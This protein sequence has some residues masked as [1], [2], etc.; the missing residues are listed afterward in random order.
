M[1]KNANQPNLNPKPLRRRRPA[2][3]LRF[4]PTAW[5]KLLF[6]RD[7][8]DTEIGGFGI[9]DADDLL[10]VREFVSVRQSVTMAS[11]SFDDQSVADYF[12]HQVDAGHKPEQF[13]RIWLHL[14]PS[15]LSRPKSSDL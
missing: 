3:V 14:N 7:R 1:Q 6:F 9:T 12:D 10:Y 13:G 11:I 2:P 5:A 15:P 4:C 8:G